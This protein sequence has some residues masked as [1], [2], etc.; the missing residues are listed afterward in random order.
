MPAG[1]VATTT[2]MNN[3]SAC[4][5]FLLGKPMARAHASGTAQ[6]LTGTAC[7]FATLDFDTDS[8]WSSGS[9]TRLTA[10]TPGWYKVR[11]G[12]ISTA[13]GANGDAWVRSTTGNNNPGGAGITSAVHWSSSQITFVTSPFGTMS[14]SGVW[15]FYMYVGD[16]WEVLADAI[17][18]TTAALPC[19][20]AAEWVSM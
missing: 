17:T 14:C 19:Y 3:L 7:A 13:S 9:N 6:T 5:T 12:I 18:D 11:Y 10:Q 1:Y 4:C 15:P 2:D 16:Y 8:M 20:F